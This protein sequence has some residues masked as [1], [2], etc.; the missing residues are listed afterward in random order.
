MPSSEIRVEQLEFLSRA[1]AR[2]STQ[3]STGAKF[4]RLK[5]DDD[6]RRCGGRKKSFF[7]NL[8]KERHREKQE[9]KEQRIDGMRM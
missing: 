5:W 1:R 6:G 7:K 3:E 2:H 4:S 9:K 8:T